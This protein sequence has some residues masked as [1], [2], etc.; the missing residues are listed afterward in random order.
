MDSTPDTP[1]GP[2]DDKAGNRAAT[3]CFLAEYAPKLVRCRNRRDIKALTA[4]IEQ[5][6][7]E[8]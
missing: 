6:T 7:G 1:T 5:V 4:K 2:E 3:I 8:R